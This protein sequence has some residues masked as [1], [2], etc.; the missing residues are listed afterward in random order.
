MSQI[1]DAQV[2]AVAQEIHRQLAARGVAA[3]PASFDVA[4]GM[5]LREGEPGGGDSRVVVFVADQR[6]PLVVEV[7]MQLVQHPYWQARINGQGA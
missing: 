2:Q 3:E 7:L 4:S 5:P 6:V 1:D